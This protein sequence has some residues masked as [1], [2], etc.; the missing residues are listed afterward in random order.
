MRPLILF[1]LSLCF[2]SAG[3][4]HHAYGHVPA[5]G[6]AKSAKQSVKAAAQAQLG[7]RS[8]HSS[9]IK[10]AVASEDGNSI[11]SDEDDDN[12]FARKYL[13]ATCPL[14]LS[15]AIVLTFAGIHRK[16]RLPSCSHLYCTS[17]PRYISQRSLRI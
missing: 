5:T 16:E 4:N 3:L 9:L 8:Q 2:L 15:Y 17:A 10:A 1:F 7:E 14:L 6:M 11:I 12:I 13:L